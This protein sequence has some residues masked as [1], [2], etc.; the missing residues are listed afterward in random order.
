MRKLYAW[1]VAYLFIVLSYGASSGFYVSIYGEDNPVSNALSIAITI[2]GVGLAGLFIVMGNK[3]TAQQY[4]NQGFRIS[5]EDE[6]L[7]KQIK[8]SWNFQ[9]EAFVKLNNKGDD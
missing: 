1:G 4:I 9:D 5:T 6:E 2:A 3:M 8:L 7:I